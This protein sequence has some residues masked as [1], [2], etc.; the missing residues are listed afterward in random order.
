MK[1]VI[2]GSCVSLPEG[3]RMNTSEKVQTGG[4]QQ[5]WRT[6][7]NRPSK[8]WRIIGKEHERT[9]IHWIGLR[10]N[11]NRKPWFLPSNIGLSY[12]IPSGKLT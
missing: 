1:T 6:V 12:H 7:E 2:F 5:K 11:F 8:F 9:T 3:R 4:D 10:E